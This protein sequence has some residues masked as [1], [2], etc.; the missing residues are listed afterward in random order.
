MDKCKK[1]SKELTSWSKF[2]DMEMKQNTAY[3]VVGSVVN[4]LGH[5]FWG[6]AL[7]KRDGCEHWA[8]DLYFCKN[9]GTYHL[10]C[11]NCGH[12]IILSEMPKNGKTQAVCGV[13][14]DKTLYARDFNMG[15]A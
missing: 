13:C 2:K 15:G 4:G 12:L 9:C 7:Y 8:S 5:M 10:R 11:P 1:C 3:A 6:N 14:G